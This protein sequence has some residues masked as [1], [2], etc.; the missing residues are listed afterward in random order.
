MLL[1]K[2]WFVLPYELKKINFSGVSNFRYPEEFVEKMLLAFTKKGDIIFDPFAGFGTTLFVAQKLGRVG[3][4]IECDAKRYKYI[5]EKIKLPSKI[6]H[7]DSLKLASYDLPLFDFSLTSPPYMRSIDKE[8]PFRSSQNPH[9]YSSYLKD[10]QKIY[11]Q[12]KS[13]MKKNAIIILEVSNT[14]EKGHPMTPLA[15]DIAK[16]VSSVFYLEREII[17]C[18]ENLK[19][20]K[21][22]A[23][24][25]YCLI[26]KNK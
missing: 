18:H 5:N 13:K 1:K 16:V 10:I 25:S 4:G 8:N 12:L 26:F 15:W 23:N 9:A 19:D 21:G 11:L 3:I 24:H 2:S 6:I 17:Y 22:Q 14:F 7:G 20:K